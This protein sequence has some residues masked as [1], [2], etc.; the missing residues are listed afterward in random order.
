MT[1]AHIVRSGRGRPAYNIIGQ[2]FERLLVIDRAP[3]I[4]HRSRWRCQCDCGAVVVVL[5][6][7][8]RQGAAKSCGCLRREFAAAQGRSMR[9]KTI[10]RRAPNDRAERDRNSSAPA[11]RTNRLARA[12]ADVFGAAP[13]TKHVDRPGARLVRGSR[14]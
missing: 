4:D 11:L 9:G 2:R 12:A 13:D 14:Y 7:L 8:L 1:D 10:K 5:G 6:Q 3:K